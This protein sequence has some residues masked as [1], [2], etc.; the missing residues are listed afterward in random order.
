MFINRRY[1]RRPRALKSVAYCNMLVGHYRDKRTSQPYPAIVIP[2][3][4]PILP[5]IA[6]QGSP[7][8]DLDH[9]TL[10]SST[11]AEKPDISWWTKV[12]SLS[13]QDD[14]RSIIL[15]ASTGSD[16][17]RFYSFA[18]LQALNT[19]STYR[20]FSHAFNATDKSIYI[21]YEVALFNTRASI[22]INVYD[23]RKKNNNEARQIHFLAADR[24]IK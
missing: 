24:I 2:A 1:R 16:P 5:D 14:Y 9:P 21:N 3:T 4:T 8:Q 10:T 22:D 13:I 6:S 19:S 12:L 23:P 11:K 20:H 7:N 17:L 15:I 18:K